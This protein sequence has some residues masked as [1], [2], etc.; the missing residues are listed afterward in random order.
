MNANETPVKA[1][2]VTSIDVVRGLVCVLMAIDHVRV[3]SG[4]PAGG[5]TYGIFFTRWVTHFVAPAFVFVAGTG[6]FLHGQKLGDRS[7]LAS[8]LIS[9]GLW[10]V[11]L[12]LTLLRFAWTFNFDYAHYSLAGVIWMLG[13]CMVLL[14]GFI[15][16]PMP[17]IA[18]IGVLMIVVQPVFYPMLGALHATEG[19]PLAALL[20]V[21]YLGGGFALGPNG[22]PV[23]VLFVI[24]PWIGLM[25][26]GYAFGPVMRW[27]PERRRSFCLRLGVALTLLFVVLRGLSVGDGGNWHDRVSKGWP[28]LL[29]FLGTSK[30]PPS[31][32]FLL[33]TIGPTLILL[34]LVESAKG[35]VARMLETFGRVPLFYYILHIPTIHIA[36]I[37]VS[38]IRTGEAN[39][40]LFANHPMNP[41]QQPA[42]YQ[43]SLPLLYLVWAVC[44]TLLYFPC[45]WYAEKKAKSRNP[46]LSY[47]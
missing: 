44:V 15:Y 6:A 4:Q 27:T 17:A 36:A 45:R 37:V 25:A 41:G 43:W 26:A 22:P 7:K 32:D 47:L 13:W 5:P 42:G 39:P 28:T 34:A 35:A 3:Y 21:L 33:M 20:N 30:Y 19:G 29:A 40:W 31:L 38:L 2:R 46:L 9:R 23:L 12:E 10:L 1:A 8:F 14:A 16:L 24:V 11:I 18:T